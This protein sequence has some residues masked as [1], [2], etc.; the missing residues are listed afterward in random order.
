MRVHCCQASGCLVPL[1]RL[2]LMCPRHWAM[3]PT[4]IQVE[5]ANSYQR[6]ACINS[7]AYY[8][9]CADAIEFVARQENRPATNRYRTITKRF[10]MR[11]EKRAS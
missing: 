3:V 8:E 9:S 10:K 4:S 6:S 2:H 11:A 1:Q 5:I 7:A